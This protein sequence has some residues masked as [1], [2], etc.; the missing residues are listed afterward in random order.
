MDGN[1]ACSGCRGSFV[2]EMRAGQDAEKLGGRIEGGEGEEG[3]E[4]ILAVVVN[5]LSPGAVWA[6]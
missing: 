2:V 5:P 6:H 1:G 4:L 3:E